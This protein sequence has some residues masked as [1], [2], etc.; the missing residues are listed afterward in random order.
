MGLNGWPLEEKDADALG[1]KAVGSR[2]LDTKAGDRGQKR[3]TGREQVPPKGK[4]EGDLKHPPK[5]IWGMTDEFR[6]YEARE[7]VRTL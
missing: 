1:G 2:V 7:T 6:S 4:R 5:G 3:E